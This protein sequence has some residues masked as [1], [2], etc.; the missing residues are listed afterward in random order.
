MYLATLSLH[1]QAAPTADSPEVKVQSEHPKYWT[2]TI[3]ADTTGEP[4]ANRW[5]GLD[6]FM[7]WQNNLLLSKIDK[8]YESVWCEHY[9]TPY[10]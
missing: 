4:E 7:C 9:T 6:F 10:Q 2:N 5:R 1:S 8:F 3:E